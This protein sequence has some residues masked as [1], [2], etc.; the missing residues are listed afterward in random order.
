MVR[1]DL[2]ARSR[3]E[4]LHC[5]VEI[6][7]NRTLNELGKKEGPDVHTKDSSS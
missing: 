3:I 7:L 6:R 4:I 1:P 5:W 2:I